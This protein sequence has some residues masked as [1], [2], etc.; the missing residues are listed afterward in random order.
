MCGRC[1][2]KLLHLDIF[3]LYQSYLLDCIT[4]KGKLLW[5]LL[6]FQNKDFKAPDNTLPPLLVEAHGGPTASASI[7][8]D[9]GKQYYTSRGFAILDVD[10]RGST[11]YGRNFRNSLY[12][13]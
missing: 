4:N 3:Y 7:A 12:G 11:G 13:K 6:L 5:Q 1:Y 9:F 8:L 2:F 10:Y